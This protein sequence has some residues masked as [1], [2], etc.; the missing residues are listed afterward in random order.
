MEL[1]KTQRENAI[2]I[3]EK[4]IS[5]QQSLKASSLDNANPLD[6]TKIVLSNFYLN[7]MKNFGDLYDSLNPHQKEEVFRFYTAVITAS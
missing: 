2:Q 4:K 3:L 7:W 5:F 1:T 6:Q